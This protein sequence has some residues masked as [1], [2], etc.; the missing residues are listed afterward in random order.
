MMPKAESGNSQFE[1]TWTYINLLYMQTYYVSECLSPVQ[2][3]CTQQRALFYLLPTYII[4]VIDLW[5]VGL[6]HSKKFTT[7]MAK[8]NSPCNPILRV[9]TN[10]ALERM[11]FLRNFSLY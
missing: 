2:E 7:V 1:G 3:T 9:D 5:L 6:E 4:N 8:I 10:Q 11:L